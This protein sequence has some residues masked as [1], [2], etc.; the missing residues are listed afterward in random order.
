M[1]VLVRVQSTYVRTASVSFQV[2]SNGKHPVRA[3]ESYVPWLLRYGG[4]AEN[5]IENDE[6]E[7]PPNLWIGFS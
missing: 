5:T 6:C 4:D 1:N 2:A 3:V 7:I